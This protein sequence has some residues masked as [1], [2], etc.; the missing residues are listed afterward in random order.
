M[1]VQTAAA[2]GRLIEGPYAFGADARRFASL[3]LTLAATDFKLQFFGSFLGYLW[4]LMRPL[5]LFGV[6][7]VVFTEF[8]RIGIEV[9]FYGAVLLTNI[10]VYTFF[11]DATGNAVTSLT[12]RD[13]LVRKVQFPLFV[14]PLSVVLR[15]YFNVILNFAAVAVFIAASGAGFHATAVELPPLLVALGVL[16][17]G[18]AAMLSALHVRF[19]DIKPIWTVVLRVLFYG[20]PILYTIELIPE[21]LQRPLLVLNPLAPVLQQVRHAVIDP[22]AASAAEA[23]G[24]WAWLLIPAA[25]AVVI[26]AVGLWV[27]RREAPHIG[28]R[29]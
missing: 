9:Q 5:L 16:A 6:L 22:S 26:F 4:Q 15:A 8:L 27:F 12:E 10:V 29:M 1:S 25:M 17:T 21:S 14:I 28:E 20:T 3:V 18:I 7:Y 24:G 2:R 11:A 19:R 13:G 23:V